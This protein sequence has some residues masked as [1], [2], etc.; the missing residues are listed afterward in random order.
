[1]VPFEF[2][3]I[4]TPAA[5]PCS[6]RSFCGITM[7]PVVKLMRLH[8]RLE[9]ST[10]SPLAAAAT[11]ERSVPEPP[12]AQL[13]TGHVVAPA[14]NGTQVQRAASAA[15]SEVR[16]ADASVGTERLARSMIAIRKGE[17]RWNAARRETAQAGRRPP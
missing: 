2:P 13:D 7:A 14:S 15:A 17:Q 11:A 4:S 6:V 5:G 8:A 9:R 16:R 3:V 10:V 1:M 12:S